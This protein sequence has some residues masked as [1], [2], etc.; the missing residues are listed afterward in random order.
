MTLGLSDEHPVKTVTVREHLDSSEHDQLSVYA[1]MWY[2]F[3]WL[4]YTYSTL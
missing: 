4:F 2:I 3:S 1:Y